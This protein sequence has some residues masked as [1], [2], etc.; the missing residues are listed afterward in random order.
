MKQFDYLICFTLLLSNGCT[1]TVAEKS[2]TKESP[3]QES[4]V[5]TTTLDIDTAQSIIRKLYVWLDTDTLIHKITPVI[6]DEYD[7]LI[8]GLDLVKINSI[9]LELKKRTFFL[10]NLSITINRLLPI[11]IKK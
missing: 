9:A 1:P 3:H 5:K 2:T 7:S 8:I 6:T 4:V 10:R 11:L